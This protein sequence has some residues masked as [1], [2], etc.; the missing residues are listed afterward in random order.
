MSLTVVLIPAYQLV[1]PST[2]ST[3]LQ[4]WCSE[5]VKESELHTQPQLLEFIQLEA[6]FFLTADEVLAKWKQYHHLPSN[7]LFLLTLKMKDHSNKIFLYHF[8]I[9]QA[10]QDEII[11]KNTSCY[12][13]E[14]C[15]TF[16]LLDS[17]TIA[18]SLLFGDSIAVA[19]VCGRAFRFILRPMMEMRRLRRITLHIFWFKRVESSFALRK[20]STNAITIARPR[21]IIKM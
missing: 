8:I 9:K 15:S 1:V 20:N 5:Q 17:S 4:R 12:A 11:R 10:P 14:V 3:F 18:S 21:P 7:G 19:M 16:N 6:Y 13:Y 2:K